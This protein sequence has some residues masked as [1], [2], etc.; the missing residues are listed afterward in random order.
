M[1]EQRAQLITEAEAVKGKSP[2]Q[3]P[4]GQSVSERRD[5]RFEPSR[6]R[7]TYVGDIM[8]FGAMVETGE[9]PRDEPMAVA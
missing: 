8:M 4:V 1:V 7:Q 3:Q 2:L 9:G 6:R 5:L